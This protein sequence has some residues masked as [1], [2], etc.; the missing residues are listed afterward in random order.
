MGGEQHSAAVRRRGPHD[1]FEDGAAVLVES[2]V[3]LVEEQQPGPAGERDRE[4]EAAPLALR[5]PAV[6]HVRDPPEGDAVQRGVGIRRGVAARPGREAQVLDDGEVVV[7]ERLVTDERERSTR[8]PAVAGEVD[9]EHLCLPGA[10][11]EETGA[12][13]QQRGLPGAV[14]P[15]QQHD[16]A[17]VDVQVG[18]GERGKPPEHA[19]GR[20]KANAVQPDSENGEW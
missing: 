14:R 5:Q 13:A 1:L 9:A 3:R 11:R 8:A 12:Q 7:T 4:R 18:A 15:A 6:R 2:G 10:Q 19:D 20:S 17:R 16:L